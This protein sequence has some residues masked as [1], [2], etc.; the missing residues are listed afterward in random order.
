[1]I[2]RQ[3]RS[4]RTDTLFPY[5]TLFRSGLVIGAL[6]ITGLSFG[7]TLQLLSAS[8]NNLYVLLGVTAMV[9]VVLGM[10]M[11][12]VGVYVILATLAAPALVEAGISAI[13]AHMFVMYF[14]MLSMI[15]PPVAL[16]AF[17]AANIAGPDPG[18]TG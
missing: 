14:G 17:A 15:T 9:A 4:T 7:L 10:G 18:K 12:T 8:G 1:M 11:P 2:R 3:P 13:P 16:A 6:N 5:T